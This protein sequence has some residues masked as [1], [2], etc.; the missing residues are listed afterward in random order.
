M[1][2]VFHL[3][4]LFPFL[5][6]PESN[7]NIYQ[8]YSFAFSRIPYNWN[9]AACSLQPG[10]FHNSN[11]HFWFRLRFLGYAFCVSVRVLQ[12]KRTNYIF[13]MRSLLTWWWRLRS[14]KIRIWQMEIQESW[15]YKFQF[16]SESEGRRHMFQLQVSQAKRGNIPLL[17]QE[18]SLI[19]FVLCF[20]CSK[21]VIIN[22]WALFL[23]EQ[24]PELSTNIFLFCFCFFL[25]K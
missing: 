6:I 10:Y 4:N 21:D 18:K 13:I 5:Q 15:W 17:S 16:K 19:F 9:D 11:M 1:S 2:L 23:L 25:L 8:F 7:V 14:R 24:K 22:F 12:R 3:V 20:S